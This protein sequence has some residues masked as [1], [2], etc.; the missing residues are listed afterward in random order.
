MMCFSR[1]LLLHC[2]ASAP[3]SS[4]RALVAGGDG[5]LSTL[6][7]ED[8][9]SRLDESAGTGMS[10]VAAFGMF[11]R[12]IRGVG[13]ERACDSGL[14]QNVSRFQSLQLKFSNR[15]PS[16]IACDVFENSDH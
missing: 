3:L 2:I 7:S 11:E 4:G 5:M 9:E 8:S 14:Q 15:L 1:P 10:V 12:D 13:V 6:P 16:S